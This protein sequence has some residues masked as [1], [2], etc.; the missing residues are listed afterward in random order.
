[1]VGLFFCGYCLGFWVALGFAALTCVRLFDPWWALDYVM[2]G[3]AVAW[4]A[5]W[6]WA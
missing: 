5:A 1:M 4:L 6:Q 2:T 3:L